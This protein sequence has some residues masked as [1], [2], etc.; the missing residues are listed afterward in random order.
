M[1]HFLSTGLTLAALALLEPAGSTQANAPRVSTAP[2]GGSATLRAGRTD[3]YSWRYYR[4]GN[5]GIQG[6]FSEA[7]WIGPDGDPWIGGYDP[8]FEEGGI[9]K[10]VQAENRWINI[11]N[12]DHPVIGHPDDTGTSRVSD[13]VADATGR[14]WLATGRGALSFDPSV[15]PS[16]LVKYDARN[17]TLPGGWTEDVERAQIGRAHV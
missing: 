5:T 8:S 7:L 12:V 9:A 15:G 13:I 17:S 1:K 14:L 6:D 3:S 2:G 10:F 11:S 4:P 16:S